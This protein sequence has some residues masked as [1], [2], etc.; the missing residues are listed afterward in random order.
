M[1]HCFVFLMV[2]LL[3]SPDCSLLI[4]VLTDGTVIMQ[5]QGFSYLLTLNIQ[6]ALCSNMSAMQNGAA[7]IVVYLNLVTGTQAG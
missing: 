1:P 3:L 6:G 4:L 2:L 5:L 7:A